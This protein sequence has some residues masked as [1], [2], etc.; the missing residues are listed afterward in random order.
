MRRLWVR[1]IFLWSFALKIFTEHP[2]RVTFYPI[3]SER[4]TGQVNLAVAYEDL[5]GELII[6]IRPFQSVAREE[7]SHIS[8]PQG[9]TA[10]HRRKGITQSRTRIVFFFYSSSYGTFKMR[11]IY[12]TWTRE[13][14]GKEYSQTGC[15]GSRKRACSV[16]SRLSVD[17]FKGT[18]SLTLFQ[19]VCSLFK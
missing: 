15:S 4:G 16:N 5:L 8:D 3:H 7:L 2:F 10:R 6:L 18:S 12:L 11:C 1:D 19:M 9:L 17:L 14:G 13:R